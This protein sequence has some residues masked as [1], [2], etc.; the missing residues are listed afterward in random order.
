MYKAIMFD[1]DGTLLPMNQE[2]F[3]KEYFRL[4]YKETSSYLSF[5]KLCSCIWSGV[6][7]MVKN[8]GF[9][10]NREVFWNDFEMTSGISRKVFEPLCDD[11]Y[12]DGFKKTKIYTNSNV[13]AKEAVK[14][15][16]Q[17]AGKVILATNPVFPL[18]AQG[19]RLSFVDL[20]VEDFDLVT[21]YESESFAKPNPKYYFS[22]CERLKID[23]KDCLMIGNDENED[24]YASSVVGV[25]T[26]MVLGSE[27]LSK[28]HPYNGNRGSFKEMVEM[29]GDLV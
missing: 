20:K 13:L 29:L 1:L 16:H 12:V 26:Y 21:S 2:E 28:K 10:I 6:K 27:I 11:F 18:V 25:N 3:T 8:D 7:A 24:M 17:K 23:P 15:A 5:E 22:I 9:M 14:L 4:L 19:T